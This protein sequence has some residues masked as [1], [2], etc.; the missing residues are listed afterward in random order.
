MPIRNKKGLTHNQQL[1]ELQYSPAVFKYNVAADTSTAAVA[2]VAPFAMEIFDIIVN[3]QATSGSGT[4]TPRKGAT[5]AM[6]T[7]IAC[8]T[9]GV[10]SHMAAGTV[11]ANAARLILAKGD[12][13][14]VIANGSTDRGIVTFMAA[15]L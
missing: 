15:R 2:F 4:I 11:V 12:S 10:V 8:A 5:D 14:Y 9:D 13:V 6:C 3:A 7:A 1:N